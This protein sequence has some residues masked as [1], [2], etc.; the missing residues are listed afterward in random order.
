M[1]VFIWSGAIQLFVGPASFSST[2]QIKVRSSTRATSE[3]SDAQWNELGLMSSLRRVKVP[4]ATR[5]SVSVAHSA[6]EPVTHEMRSGVVSVAT[7]ATQAARRLW[8]VLPS[9]WI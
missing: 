7:S 6:S 5:L 8:L 3:G 1:T 9:L 2:E 4:V